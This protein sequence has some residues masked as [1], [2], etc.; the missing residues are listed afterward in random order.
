M[1][2]TIIGAGNVATHLAEELSKLKDVNILQIFSKTENS[3]KILAEKINCNW[4]TNIFKI[5]DSDLYIISTNDDSIKEIAQI[6]QLKNKFIVHTSGS[7]EMKILS[8]NTTNY[9]VFY[10]LQTFKKEQNVNFSEI[11]MCIEASSTQ[12][13]DILQN[14]AEKICKKA[15][16]INSTQR[17][18]IHIAAIF[19]NNFTNHLFHIANEIISI[20][21]VSIEILKPLI[22][23]TFQ[24]IQKNNPYNIQTGPAKRKDFEIINK[25]IEALKTVNV[26]FAEVYRSISNSIG[27]MY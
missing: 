21:D 5:A 20:N 25:H 17:Q 10:P 26:N 8:K 27:K 24:N 22:E 3:A 6:K 18:N 19:V 11:P 7:V 13:F 2:I 15:Y 1:K 4:T 14:L 16:K 12:N 23:Q 9:G